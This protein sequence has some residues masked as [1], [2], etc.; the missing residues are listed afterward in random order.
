MNLINY[1]INKIKKFLINK[2]IFKKTNYINFN[3]IISKK[4]IK[5]NKEYLY[6][7][8]NAVSE[9]NID[10]SKILNLKKIKIPSRANLKPI[11][12]SIIFS[13][14]LGENKVIP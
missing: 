10:Y 3:D 12:N 14:L 9:L 13:K 11:N 5:R 2:Y 4:V 7:Q 1:L 6:I 8:T